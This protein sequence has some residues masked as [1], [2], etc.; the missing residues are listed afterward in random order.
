MTDDLAA[1]FG[2]SDTFKLIMLF[3]I[4]FNVLCEAVVTY[5]QV[6]SLFPTGFFLVNTIFLGFY[7]ME[8]MFKWYYGFVDFW[9]S[10]WN[11]MDLVLTVCYCLKSYSSF[12]GR[13]NVFRMLKFL[14]RF[15]S[16]SLGWIKGM[17]IVV[18]TIAESVPN[19]ANIAILLAILMYIYSIVGV[20]LFQ[21]VAQEEFGNLGKTMFTLFITFTQIG[22]VVILD[23]LT[24][25]G[26]FLAGSIY[27]ISFI[28]IG[29]VI[30]VKTVVAVVVANLEDAYQHQKVL[31][32]MKKKVLK[33]NATDLKSNF[34]CN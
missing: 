7:I 8:I 25:N 15:K 1:R 18:T 19:M 22:W 5:P 11:V 24:A 21:D 32:K 3:I 10:M 4:L 26:Y 34:S 29:V 17:Q 33:S 6:Y 30:F 23:K 16:K 2:E 27:F 9:R 14:Q 12:L 28:L 31:D 13:I 20:A